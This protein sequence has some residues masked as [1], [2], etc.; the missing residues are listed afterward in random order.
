MNKIIRLGD[1]IYCRIV[2]SRGRMSITGAVGP[3][4]DGNADG[5]CGQIV[6]SLKP[7][8]IRRFAPGWDAARAKKFLCIWRRWHLNDIQAGTPSQMRA[9]R[10][11]EVLL[12]GEHI[13]DYFAWAMSTL[14]AANL[15]P[16]P[17]YLVQGRPYRYG[18][19]WLT[20]PVPSGV[21]AWLQSLPDTDRTPAWV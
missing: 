19:D 3:R 7:E 5:P 18:T 2:V 12:A 14:A 10:R 15:E 20:E 4:S 9:L 11:A 16:D 21:I 13:V 8:H 6:M 17:G 1:T